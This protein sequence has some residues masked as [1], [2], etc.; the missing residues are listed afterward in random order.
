MPPA[1]GTRNQM[2]SSLRTSFKLACQYRLARVSRINYLRGPNPIVLLKAA[3]RAFLGRLFLSKD[4]RTIFCKSMWAGLL[5]VSGSKLYKSIIKL[6]TTWLAEGNWVKASE[7]GFSW[8]FE[9][10]V[11]H[12][13]I[14]L[15][16]FDK[17]INDKICKL[18][19]SDDVQKNFVLMTTK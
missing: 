18:S 19:S 13:N 3:L 12:Y 10:L 5:W 4:P 14:H 17:C 11:L 7:T 9:Y 8:I 2:H 15:Y 1:N 6:S 16:K